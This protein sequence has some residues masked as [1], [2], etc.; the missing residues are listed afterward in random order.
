M[1]TTSPLPI[2][3]EKDSIGRRFSLLILFCCLAFVTLAPSGQSL[4]IDEGHA[5]EIFQNPDFHKVV[6]STISD[7]GSQ[8]QMPGFILSA[9]LGSR[10]LGAGEYEMRLPNLIWGWLAVVL[11]WL[12]GRMVSSASLPVLLASSPF[13]WFYMDEARPY[14]MQIAGGAAS[15]YALARLLTFSQFDWKFAISWTLGAILMGSA[16]MLG[17]FCVMALTL[18]AFVS[19]IRSKTAIQLPPFILV[20]FGYLLM[21]TLGVYYLWTILRGAGGAKLWTVSAGNIGF[22]FYELLGFAGLGPGRLA[23]R[24][25]AKSGTGE[26][27]RTLLPFTPWLMLLAIILAIAFFLILR[28]KPGLPRKLVIANFAILVIGISCLTLAAYVAKWPFWGR[29]FAPFLPFLIVSVAVGIQHSTMPAILRNGTLAALIGIW[30]FSSLN[31][32]FLDRHMKDDYR[33]AVGIACQLLHKSK[34]VWWAADQATAEYYMLPVSESAGT[35]K[36]LSLYMPDEAKLLSLPHPDIIILSRPDQFDAP[37][38]I[39][40]YLERNNYQQTESFVGFSIWKGRT[41]GK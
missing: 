21:A 24:E 36:A 33:R 40:D 2:K 12:T 32:R 16:S 39:R 17:G 7:A 28:C 35:N 6:V 1:S 20:C 41:T 15:A 27:V 37:G 9:W 30:S 18:L 13:L 10:L 34:S 23:L 11:L 8:A 29:H 26:A 5:A 19:A 4:W 38:A 22:A 3:Q 25:A 31:I 14:A